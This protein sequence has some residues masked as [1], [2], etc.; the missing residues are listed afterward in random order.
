MENGARWRKRR[1]VR[2]DLIG[3]IAALDPIIG[4]AI[5]ESSD[6]A[7]HSRWLQAAME[8]LF[9]ALSGSLVFTTSN[10]RAASAFLSSKSRD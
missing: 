10:M 7:Y 1:E 5:G 8:G 9:A 4:D 3:R 2:R 6:L